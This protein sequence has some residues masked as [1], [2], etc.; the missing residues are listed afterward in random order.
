MKHLNWGLLQLGL[1]DQQCIHKACP[2]TSLERGRVPKD[3]GA[4][5]EEGAAAMKRVGLCL[6]LLMVGDVESSQAGRYPIPV[7]MEVTP[8]PPPKHQ[9]TAAPQLAAPAKCCK[10]PQHSCWCGHIRRASGSGTAEVVECWDS[11]AKVSVSGGDI[12]PENIAADYAETAASRWEC[13]L[14][15]GQLGLDSID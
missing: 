15:I 12:K 1:V 2:G 5:L 8:A 6:G 14:I 7:G 9:Q 4:D 13:G 10:Y 11:C 3:P